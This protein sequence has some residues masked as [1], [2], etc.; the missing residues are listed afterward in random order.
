M[1]EQQ[2]GRADEGPESR[3]RIL[4]AALRL[5]GSRGFQETSVAEIARAAGVSKGLVYHY[6]DTKRDVLG[7][8]FER[9]SDRL[10]RTLRE[11]REG[12][13]AV[14]PAAVVMEVL[15]LVAEDLRWWRLLFRLRMQ[16]GPGEELGRA[17]GR[18]L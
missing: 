7:A 14:P 16:P 18:A 9:G 1:D 15:G 4:E 5:F 10:E 3:E 13:A 12:E 8:V 11:A 6:F 17:W 2:G